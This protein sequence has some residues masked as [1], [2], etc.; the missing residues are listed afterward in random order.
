MAE[1]WRSEDMEL[2]QLYIQNEAAHDTIEEL[3]KLGIVQFRDVSDLFLLILLT[4][5]S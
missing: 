4:L 1:L 3:G 5:D 2:I